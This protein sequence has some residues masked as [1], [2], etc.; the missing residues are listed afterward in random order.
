MARDDS[1]FGEASGR[2]RWFRGEPQ[3]TETRVVAYEQRW[4][5]PHE[6]CPGE[7]TFNGRSW[8]LSSPGYHHTCDKCGF[9]AAI[10][11]L[12]IPGLCIG[13]SQHD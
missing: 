6:D 1:K 11:A 8:P 9:T 12:S 7:M 10:L 5:C 13:R 2:S 3:V 4:Q